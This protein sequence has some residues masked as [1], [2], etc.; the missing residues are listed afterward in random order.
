MSEF[1]NYL[2][3]KL[4][5]ITLR[6][7]AAYTVATPYIALLES[8]PTDADIGTEASW[9]GYARQLG[10]FGVP[11]NGV[12]QITA[13]VNFPAVAGGQVTVTH[14]AIYDA[15]SGG[16]LLYHTILDTP[17]VLEVSDVLTFAVSGFTVILS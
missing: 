13:E 6:A 12:S 17:R 14:A 5:E 3:D 1:S 4:L 11:V 10:A 7:G 16:N 9:A 8:D 15:V 2:E